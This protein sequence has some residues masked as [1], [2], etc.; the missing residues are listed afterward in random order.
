M[1]TTGDLTE[2]LLPQ[3]ISTNGYFSSW[4]ALSS[5]TTAQ[6]LTDDHIVHGI[7]VSNASKTRAK[8]KIYDMAE[9]I[10]KTHL[11]VTIY[12]LL[13]LPWVREIHIYICMFIDAY[14]VQNI[15]T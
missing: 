3:I 5:A 11:K 15:E 2:L 10:H 8:K 13:V 12:R 4:A 6:T 9:S 14:C 7:E 1:T